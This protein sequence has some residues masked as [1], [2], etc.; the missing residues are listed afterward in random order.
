MK[1]KESSN[2][3]AWSIESDAR[4]S[5]LTSLHPKGLII[6]GAIISL[7]LL[8]GTALYLNQPVLV[9]YDQ[10][11]GENFVTLPVETGDVLEYNWI[12]SFEHI[13]W[14]ERYIVQADHGLML[15][16]IQ[17]A[18]FGAGIP[19]NKGITSVENGMVVMGE[20]EER[21]D[22]ISWI[23]SNTALSSIVLNGQT[24]ASGPDLPHHQPLRLEIK[25]RLRTWLVNR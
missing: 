16:E 5:P 22:V 17:V 12:H 13:P 20:L 2:A 19:E 6:L 23:H 15:V 7:L 3:I 14:N 8:I 25:R 10:Q 21:F 18:G 24:V 4:K 9:I 1:N 11:T